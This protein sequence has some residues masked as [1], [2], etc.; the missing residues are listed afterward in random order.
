MKAVLFIAHL[1]LLFCVGCAVSGHYVSSGPC[2]GFHTNQLACQ[3]AAENA[4]AIVQVK[5]GQTIEEVSKIMGR[6]PERREAAVD[7]ETWSYL[8][9][10]EHELMTTIIFGEGIVTE[11][12]QTPWAPEQSQGTQ[13]RGASNTC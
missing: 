12:K 10:Y 11:I 2:K 4:V 13:S 5:I 8:T 3:R 9:D 7:R 6:A 1:T